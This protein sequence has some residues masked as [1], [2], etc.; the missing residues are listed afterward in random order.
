MI[1][2]LHEMI[3]APILMTS[4]YIMANPSATTQNVQFL[5]ICSLGLHG[6]I[7]SLSVS[8]DDRFNDNLKS[9]RGPVCIIMA[10]ITFVLYM[11]IIIITYGVLTNT[12]LGLFFVFETILLVWKLFFGCCAILMHDNMYFR[13]AFYLSRYVYALAIIV[14]LGL[15]QTQY[16]GEKDKWSNHPIIWANVIGQSIL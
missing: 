15:M 4:L 3:T 11:T 2:N 8:V 13:V 10:V 14:C 16:I 6:S 9:H 5:F 1:Y 12:I 7:A